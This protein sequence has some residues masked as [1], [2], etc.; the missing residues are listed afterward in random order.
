M[1]N[2]DRL[3]DRRR[4]W[5]TV[6]RAKDATSVSWYQET[7]SVSLK[8]IEATGLGHGARI[9]DVGG[10]ASTLVDRLIADGYERVTVLDTAPAALEQARIRLGA[11]ADRVDWVVEDVT[12]WRPARKYDLWHDR[13]VFH[14]LTIAEDRR[15]YLAVMDE[16]LEPRGQAIIATFALDGPEKCSGLPV[17]RYGPESLSRELG[18]GFALLGQQRERHVTPTGVVQ[19]FLYCHFQ[20]R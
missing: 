10:G 13:A 16:A 17:M 18:Q 9:I 3:A 7:L 6:Y 12:R 5:E 19:P 20:R 8:M 11:D 1:A 15:A 14:F 4:H 2:T